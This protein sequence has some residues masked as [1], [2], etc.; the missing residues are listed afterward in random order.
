MTLRRI[1]ADRNAAQL[2]ALGALPVQA[3]DKD[4]V[5]PDPAIESQAVLRTA[6]AEGAVAVLRTSVAP[7]ATMATPGPSIGIGIG[8][9]GGGY[10]SGGGVGFGMSAPVGGGSIETGFS[11]NASLTDVASGQLMWSASATAPPSADL[12]RQLDDLSKLLLDTARQ[13]GFFP[14]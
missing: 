4:F 6:R 9:F 10:R 13:A 8:G 3:P 7:S 2:S 12:N 11:A 14:S 1:C 5:D